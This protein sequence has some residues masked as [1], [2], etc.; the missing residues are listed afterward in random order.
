M[1][2]QDILSHNGMRPSRSSSYQWKIVEQ[3][4]D[5]KVWPKFSQDQNL[6]P[7]LSDYQQQRKELF[8]D[9]QEEL[10]TYCVKIAKTIMTE[11]QFQIFHLYFLDGYGQ[12]EI[13]KLRNCNQSSIVKALWGNAV[14]DGVTGKTIYEVIDGKRTTKRY[15]GGIPKI[16]RYLSTDL[17]CQD[18]L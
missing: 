12:V 13:S 10:A 17:H 15:G 7:Y 4:F 11:T 14:F 16:R 6:S 8:L 18:L 1:N 2:E 3:M 5:E 9:L